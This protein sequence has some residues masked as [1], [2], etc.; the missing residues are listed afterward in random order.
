M[1]FS[2]MKKY[3][4][5][6]PLFILL[7]IL[8]SLSLHASLDLLDQAPLPHLFLTEAEAGNQK[9]PLVISLHSEIEVR[10]TGSETNLPLYS[11]GSGDQHGQRWAY[12]DRYEND[13]HDGLEPITIPASSIIH[14]PF[15]WPVNH[16]VTKSTSYRWT[17][18][19][20]KSGLFK[21]TFQK[22]YYSDA[23]VRNMDGTLPWADPIQEISFF[24]KV[25]DP[26][27]SSKL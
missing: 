23:K 26:H 12:I 6:T 17:F 13:G 14:A 16:D 25:V 18:A 20:K 5:W 11:S 22:Y 27:Q 10:L 7:V 19:G 9:D 2:D 1:Y 24:V 15:E 21:L 3:T 4:S 8:G